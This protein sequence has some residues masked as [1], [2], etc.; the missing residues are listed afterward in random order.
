MKLEPQPSPKGGAGE[1]GSHSLAKPHQSRETRRY[2]AHR[3]TA[4]GVALHA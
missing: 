2:N 4:G 3:R 1:P